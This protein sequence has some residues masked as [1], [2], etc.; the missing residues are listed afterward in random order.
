[1]NLATLKK[2]ESKRF[3]SS[4]YVYAIS[5]FLLLFGL[6]FCS[7]NIVNLLIATSYGFSYLITTIVSLVISLII[8]IS[9]DIEASKETT[10]AH[11]IY[12]S[13]DNK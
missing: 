2:D 12:S 6:I 7:W 9:L 8:L 3:N 13:A 10:I 4:P 5:L 11:K 1:M